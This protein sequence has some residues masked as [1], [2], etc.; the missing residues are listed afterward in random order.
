MLFFY[1]LDFN[2]SFLLGTAFNLQ[3]TQHRTLDLQDW[4]INPRQEG[5]RRNKL[6]EKG[7]ITQGGPIGQPLKIFLRKADHFGFPPYKMV[8]KEAGV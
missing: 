1:N 3:H 2:Q 6:L 7:N 5:R 4:Y 8:P